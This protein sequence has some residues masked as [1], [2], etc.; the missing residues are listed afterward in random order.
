MRVHVLTIAA[1]VVT[2]CGSTKQDGPPSRDEGDAAAGYEMRGV[3]RCCAPG[4]GTA[5]CEGMKQ[6]MCFAYG[7]LYGDWRRAGEQYDGKVI[8]AQCCEGLERRGVVVRGNATPP[9]V[10]GLPDGCD[11]GAPPSVL[12]CL[13]CGDGVCGTGEDFCNCPEDCGYTSRTRTV[14]KYRRSRSRS[15]GSLV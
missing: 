6:G 1:L 3:Y 9:E 14:G 12:V 7:G 5:C 11:V 8:C 13:R 2:A 15:P 4:T 10:D